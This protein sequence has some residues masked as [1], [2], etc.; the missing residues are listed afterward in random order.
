MWGSCSGHPPYPG[1]VAGSA[2]IHPG[3][4]ATR[5]SGR[6]DRRVVLSRIVLLATLCALLMCCAGAVQVLG[7]NRI[8]VTDGTGSIGAS[9]IA[10]VSLIASVG[11]GVKSRFTG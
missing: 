11:A 1:A 10:A 2:D 8:V 5:P 9:A 4:D 3:W 7:I 6:Q